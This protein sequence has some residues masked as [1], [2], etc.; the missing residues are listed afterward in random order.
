M[1]Q[2][3]WV[4]IGHLSHALTLELDSVQ[5]LGYLMLL[6]VGPGNT[7]TQ[8]VGCC[9]LHLNHIDWKS[10]GLSSPGKVWV[11]LLENGGMDVGLPETVDDLSH[12]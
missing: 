10:G 12:S 2:Q 3:L 1:S 7:P 4:F 11:L 5:S 6:L 9:Q 8:E